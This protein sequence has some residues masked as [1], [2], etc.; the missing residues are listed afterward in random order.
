MGS[1]GDNICYVVD[2]LYLQ[3]YKVGKVKHGLCNALP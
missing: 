3:S 1:G 2:I